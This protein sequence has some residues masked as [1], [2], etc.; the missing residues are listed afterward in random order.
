MVAVTPPKGNAIEQ[1]PL[2]WHTWIVGAFIVGMGIWLVEQNVSDRA[3]MILTGLILLGVMYKTRG[4]TAE[5]TSLT[6]GH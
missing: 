6:L 5:L 4:F 1:N 2:P 3:A